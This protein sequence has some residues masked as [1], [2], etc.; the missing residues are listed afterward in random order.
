MSVST[1]TDVRRRQAELLERLGLLDAAPEAEL[2]AA[3]RLAAAVTGVPRA[4][5]DAAVGG[6]PASHRSQAHGGPLQ[7]ADRA[8]GAR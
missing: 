8:E 4:A 1:E 7:G 5:V 2:D 6:P 3:V